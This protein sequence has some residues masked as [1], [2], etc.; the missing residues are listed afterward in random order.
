MKDLAAAAMLVADESDRK[1]FIEQLGQERTLYKELLGLSKKENEEL[2]KKSKSVSTLKEAFKQL[3]ST[4][5]LVGLSVAGAVVGLGGLASPAMFQQFTMAMRDLGAV[6]GQI[7]LPVFEAFTKVLRGLADFI[8]NLPSGVKSLIVTFALVAVGIG[9]AIVAVNA[10]TAAFAALNVV[11]GGILIGIGVVVTAL[12]GLTYWFTQTSTGGRMLSAFMDAMRPILDSLTMLGEALADT[13]GELVV[14]LVEVAKATLLFDENVL[15]FV[16]NALKVLIDNL[17]FTILLV[18]ELSKAMTNPLG[19]LTIG[20][21][22][23]K[24]SEKLKK[25]RDEMEKSR[26]SSVGAAPGKAGFFSLEQLGKNVAISALEAGTAKNNADAEKKAKEEQEAIDSA[27]REKVI[28][29][30]T[31]ETARW[32][33][34]IGASVP[35]FIAAAKRIWGF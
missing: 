31:A 29:K 9:I 2:E 33:A 24:A 27:E 7:L 21:A 23:D 1:K 20:G 4:A 6:V 30:A 14:A 17:T 26:K 11:S 32:A 5:K 34:E 10:L 19:F 25:L 15:R 12:A 16:T 13:F 18:G 28:A 8:I 3:G 22:A 35:P